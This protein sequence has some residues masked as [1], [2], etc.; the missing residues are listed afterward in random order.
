MDLNF[1]PDEQ[2]F[3]EKIRAWV[4]DNLPREISDKV[5]NSIRLT[6]DDMQRWAKILGKNGWLG[7][8]WPKEFG[9]PGWNA[10]Q[11][12]LFE[13]ETRSPARR[14]IVPFG[15]V[16]VAPVIMA[17]GTP[18]QQRRFLPASPAARSGGA[19]ATASRLRLR[20]R[21]AQDPAERAATSTSSTA[22]RPGPRSASTAT[23][24]SAWCAP[25]TKASRRP[26]SAS[27]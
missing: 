9:G 22:R 1:T 10:I 24:S 27:C 6:R 7:W 14:A 8:G 21:V 19:R 23:G 20:P 4:Q 5:R 26:A 3:R 25:R 12:H 15:P 13:E 16:M 18:E 2:A 11:K 17:F